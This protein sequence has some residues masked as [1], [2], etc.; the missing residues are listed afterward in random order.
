MMQPLTLTVC[1]F[2]SYPTSVTVDFTGKGLTAVL[3]DTGAGKSSILEAI[4]YALFRETTWDGRN[5]GQLI[6]DNCDA[7]SVE[8]TFRHDGQRWRV[9][10][11]MNA[12][13]PNAGRHHLTNLDTGEEVDR[14]KPVD[15]RIESVVGMSCETFL[16]VGLLP[17]GR[18]DQL[19]TAPRKERTARLREL[20][21]ADSLTE[22][23]RLAEKQ[24]ERLDGLIGQAQI[25]R[26][27]MPENP[28]QAARE[29]GAQ[30]A[31]SE[32]RA[33][34]LTDTID[35]MSELREQISMSQ[36]AAVRTTDAVRRLRDHAAT[37][38]TAA[39]DDLQPI[40]DQ[41]DAEAK[42]LNART[43]EA[44][45]L[46]SDLADQI[47]AREEAGEGLDALGKAAVTI[48][49]LAA[50]AQEHRNARAAADERTRQL[51]A[52]SEQIATAET[53]IAERLEETTV[54]TAAA[55]AA[56]R[57]AESI[58]EHAGTL[59]TGI[60]QAVAAALRAAETARAHGDALDRLGELE[61]T[62]AD[63]TAGESSAAAAL[64]AAADAV[65]TTTQRNQAAAIAID[66][67]PG[68]D[69][70][71]CHHQLPASF[72]PDTADTAT[73]LR[74]AK[75]AHQEA[76]SEHTR[77]TNESAQVRA[78]AALT[79]D[80]TN[81]LQQNLETA[82]KDASSATDIASRLLVE[83]ASIADT[84][85]ADAARTSLLS[86][87]TTLSGPGTDTDPDELTADVRAA[88]A[89]CERAADEHAR[90]QRNRVHRHT[91]TIDAERDALDNRKDRHEE[92]LRVAAA[93]SERLTAA[94]ERT[95]ADID[96]LPSHVRLLLPAEIGD[97]E[98]EQTTAAAA[99]IANSLS[100]VRELVRRRDDARREINETLSKQRTL[101]Q[102]IRTQIDTPLA[103]LYRGLRTWE[104]TAVSTLTE[105]HLDHRVPDRPAK[106]DVTDVRAFAVALAQLTATMTRELTEIN[107]GHQHATETA[108]TKLREVAATLGDID[109]F[110][111][112]ADLTTPNALHPL[113]AAKTTASRQAQELRNAESAAHAQ[114]RP[115]ADLDF[116]IAAGTARRDAVEVLRVH[117]VD[118]KFLSHL[119]THNTRALLG[120]ASDLLG[121]LTGDRF[122]FAENFDIV[123][124]GSG[125]AHSAGRLSGGEK[126]LA[127]LALALSLAELH[128]R[129]GPRLGSLFLDEGF[130]TLDTD[131]LDSALD[132]LRTQ[133]GSDRLVMVVSHL[134]AVAE[135]VDDVLW[136][137]RETTGS[138]AHWLTPSER[139]ELVNSDLISGLQALM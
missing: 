28:A 93:D 20:F 71:V 76:Q 9:S 69:C 117:L 73:E 41:L 4:T 35:T 103:E 94:L 105:H 80:Q 98:P 44:T 70:P 60:L 5:L 130:A 83:F 38:P 53:E 40:A 84:F 36:Q 21:G 34:Y 74:E 33:A 57:K 101:D 50:R 114:V 68:D 88:V 108:T 125:V 54:L 46:E 29:A 39:L 111:P 116:A 64:D 137:R 11:T 72:T 37:N 17:Q 78:T 26:K 79:R 129:S 90:S 128:S 109:G 124:R 100:Q 135:A 138:T 63:L 87:T 18:F 62:A 23:R 104:D 75:A 31:A 47:T 131:A 7:M 97:I 118:A 2:R 123:S 12:G 99:T 65:A 112:S 52:E 121:K 51:A 127:S 91:A 132:I 119:I 14:A 15:A 10:R 48:D 3:G 49:G 30:A 136:V 67:H 55:D 102:A 81:Q 92:A 59:R 96:A 85:D 126:F 106:Q 25:K 13:N 120:I 107:T 134:H 19:L 66:L 32:A 27:A 6:A 77:L 61:Q 86:S 82:R 16:R 110:D 42:A 43:T 8:F 45:T 22:A 89:H 56:E 115:A 24:K 122:G 133:A 58:H 113:V 139:D 95:A 1:G